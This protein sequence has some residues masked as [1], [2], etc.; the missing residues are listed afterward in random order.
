MITFDFYHIRLSHVTKW[1]LILKYI[2]VQVTLTLTIWHWSSQISFTYIIIIIII[3]D[4]FKYSGIINTY[5]NSY[6]VWQ[7]LL[8]WNIYI[9][10]AGCARNTRAVSN[11]RV[12]RSPSWWWRTYQRPLQGSV[13]F[14][15]CLYVLCLYSE[16]IQAL[17]SISFWVRHKSCMVLAR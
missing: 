5:S 7:D 3:T 17:S 13:G 11:T 8:C 9:S 4:I 1:I 6:Y 2:R 15:G 10:Q 14:S 12:R 16:S